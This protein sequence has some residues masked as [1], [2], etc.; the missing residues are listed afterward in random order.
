MCSWTNKLA[1]GN[2]E[3]YTHGIIQQ[4]KNGVNLYINSIKLN[5]YKLSKKA[6]IGKTKSGQ[7]RI[8]GK[9]GQHKL[10]QSALKREVV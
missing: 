1:L 4:E 8:F 7:H 2:N 6:V 3:I 5:K 9:S 10:R